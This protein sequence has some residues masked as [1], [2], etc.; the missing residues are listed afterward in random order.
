MKRKKG[1]TYYVACCM[2]NPET[3][4]IYCCFSFKIIYAYHFLLDHES[5]KVDN[6]NFL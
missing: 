6:S 1:T 5:I 3:N 2:T 4:K